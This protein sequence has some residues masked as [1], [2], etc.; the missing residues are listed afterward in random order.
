MNKS[1]KVRKKTITFELDDLDQDIIRELRVNG[2]QSWRE[3][4]KK[5]NVSPVTIM[6]RIRALEDSEIIRGY[7]VKLD[8]KKMGLELASFIG[9]TV[10]GTDYDMVAN[11]L[12]ETPEVSEVYATTGEFDLIAFFRAK[13]ID[14]F[15]K[16]VQSTYKQRG[17][18]TATYIAVALKENYE[19]IAEPSGYWRPAEKSGK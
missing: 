19:R 8:Y 3:I 2:R 5:L 7:T 13:S 1:K 16:I 10:S 14:E 18:K 15:A 11:H 9:I 17:V 4:A 6:N 12:I